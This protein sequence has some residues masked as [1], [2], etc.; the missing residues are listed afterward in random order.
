MKLVD[1]KRETVSTSDDGGVAEATPYPSGLRLVLDDAALDR[2]GLD[3]V[4]VG[5]I[6]SLEARAKVV[7]YAENAAALDTI[8][9]RLE[10]Q[11]TELAIDGDRVAA[12]ER[13][14][15]ERLNE[16]GGYA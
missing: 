9:C 5:D 4:V 1:M 14:D 7:G 10:L 3:D 2:L 11:I 8:A 6:V 16:L 15:G 12:R 13:R